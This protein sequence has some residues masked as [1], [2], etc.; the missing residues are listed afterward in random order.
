MAKTEVGARLLIARLMVIGGFG[1]AFALALIV[2]LPGGS[3]QVLVVLA[4]L[5]VLSAVSAVTYIIGTHRRARQDATSRPEDVNR[6]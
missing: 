3:D 1:A 2:I 4:V 6:G 5:C